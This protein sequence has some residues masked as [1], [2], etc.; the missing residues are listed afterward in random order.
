MVFLVKYND[1]E[2]VDVAANAI[3]QLF[4]R[5]VHVL[6]EEVMASDIDIDTEIQTVR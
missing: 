5:G 4:A 6:V 3:K 1:R 2:L